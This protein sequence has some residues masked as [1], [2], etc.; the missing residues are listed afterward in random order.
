MPIIGLTGSFGSGKTTVAAMFKNAGA[1]VI[2]A[3][4]I[5]ARLLAPGGKCVKKVAKAF[6]DGILTTSHKIDRSALASIVFQDP[7]EL[8]KLTD[9]L[10]PIGLKEIK[11]QLSQYKNVKLVVLDVPLL[12]ESGWDKLTDINIVVQSNQHLQIQRLQKRTGLS[13]AS[14][15]RRMKHQMPVKEKLQRADIIINNRGTILQTHA[16]VR[17][18]VNRLQQRVN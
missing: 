6:G 4:A 14:I 8:K 12:F 16:Q 9:I 10:Y 17:A 11:K 15:M 2:D 18:I 13:K 7:R 3:D 5:T 1:K